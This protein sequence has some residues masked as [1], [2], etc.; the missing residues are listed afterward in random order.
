MT[1]L[2]LTLGA[3]LAVLAGAQA[4]SETVFG[5]IDTDADGM[6]S[7]SEFVSWRTIESNMDPV[8]AVLEFQKVDADADGSVSPEELEQAMS[9]MTPPEPAEP[10][11]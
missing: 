8:D 7:Q 5:Q 11:L 10:S 2:F 9:P 6:V 4:Q 1:R 3:T